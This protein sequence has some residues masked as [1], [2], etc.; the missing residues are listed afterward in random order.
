[1]FSTF[2]AARFYCFPFL[3]APCYV[4]YPRWKD[5]IRGGREIRCLDKRLDIRFFQKAVQP[6]VIRKILPELE[7]LPRRE[8]LISIREDLIKCKWISMAGRAV[9][10]NVYINFTLR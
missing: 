8:I 5:F 9:S 1:M 2:P 4:P 10:V 3:S 6:C 7:P